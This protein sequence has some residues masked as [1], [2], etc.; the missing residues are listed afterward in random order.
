MKNHMAYN[1][2]ARSTARNV[3]LANPP[4]K[5]MKSNRRLLPALMA[6]VLL[7]LLVPATH[8][9]ILEYDASLSGPNE[10]P[11]NGSPATG[12]AVVDYDNSAHTLLVDVSFTG[13]TGTTTASHIHAA[14]VVPGAGTAGVATTTPTFPGFPLGVFSG[15]YVHTLDL[16]L[17]TSYNAPFLTASGGTPAGAE[18]ALAAAMAAGEAYLNIHTSTFGGGEIRGFLTLVPEPSSVAIVLVCGALAWS[19]RRRTKV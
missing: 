13:L 12:S 4:T 6:P 2:T 17:A 9:A 15:T 5:T 11:P 18:A 14:T 19:A 8:A 16:T 1:T 3:V 10:S 7:A